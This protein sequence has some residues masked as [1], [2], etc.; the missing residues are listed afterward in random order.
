MSRLRSTV[1][2]VLGAALAL[3]AP[4]A[5]AAA[6]PVPTRAAAEPTLTVRG[7]GRARAT[8][9]SATIFVSVRRRAR[10]AA[11]ARTQANDRTR[12]VIA[13]LVGTGLDRAELQ[14]STIGLRREAPRRGQ[15]VRGRFV[16]SASI[17]VRTRRIDLV[18]AL[19]AAATRAGADNVN[20]PNFTLADPSSAAVAATEAALT[21]ARR[22]ADAAANALGMR[23]SGVRSVG[24]DPAV[25]PS[26]PVAG[27][28]PEADSDEGRSP[29]VEPGQA[30][31]RVTVVVVF[32][33]DS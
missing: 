17:T 10:T 18:G 8:P 4:A 24:L 31:V 25:A 20:G 12:A 9:D 7:E 22:R 13:A 26:E 3:G 30:E 6:P 15:A 2:V 33:L 29:P 23:V 27:S 32:E 19:L 16:A 1:P 11:A 28:T 5:S 21:D 14:T